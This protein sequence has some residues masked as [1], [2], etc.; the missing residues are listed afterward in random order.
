M[1]ERRLDCALAIG[2]LDPGGGAGVVAD[3][4]AFHAAGVF[5]CAVVAV[6]TVQSTDGL[7]EALPVRPSLVVRQADLVVRVERVRAIKLGALGSSANVRAIARW[8]GDPRD[9]PVVLDPVIAPTLGSGRLLTSRAMHPLRDLLLPRATLVTAN[10]HEAADLTGL[11]VHT[12]DDAR[13]AARALVELGAKA[14]LVKGGH[15][16]ESGPVIDVL[17]FRSGKALELE[18][19]RLR[20]PRMHGGGCV[21]ASLIAGLLA[22]T[23]GRGDASIASAVRRGRVIHQRALAMAADVGGRARVLLPRGVR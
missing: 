7:E 4:R 20:L 16:D 10:A 11:R 8:L 17:A 21:L 23:S 5:G 14:A 15:L 18:G 3:L 1:R 2:G 6:Q 13:R 22:R 9:L 12:V 19:A